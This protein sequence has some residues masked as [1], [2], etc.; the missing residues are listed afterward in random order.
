MAI[1]FLRSIFNLKGSKFVPFLLAFLSVFIVTAFYY[2]Q[3]SFLEAFEA[4]SY[5]LRFKSLRGALQASPEI[6]IIKIDDKSIAELGRFP[7]SRGQ[8]VKLLDQLS[9]AG[10]KAV[11]F[12]IIFSEPEAKAVD[13]AFAVAVKKA[14]NVGLAVAF[15]W[16]KNHQVTKSTHTIPMIAQGAAGVGHI[17]FVPEDDGVNRRN[18]LLV[19]AD[20]VQTPS[21]GLMGAQMAL[22]ER[23]TAGMF[24]IK[25]GD[26]AIPVDADN[27]MWI[28]YMGPPNNYPS[29]S[30]S[31][32]VKGRVNP[33]HL[34]GKVLFVGATAL[35]VYDMRV[36]PFSGNTPGV[37]IHATIADNIIS[38]RFI[39]RTGLESLF[40]IAL[41]LTLGLF[42][43][44]LTKNLGFYAAFPATIV[45]S[46]VYLWFAFWM[47]QQG[48]WV[49]MIYPPLAVIISL[50]IGG[51]FRYLVLE[52][53]ARELR[54]IFSSYHSDK[55]VARLE[56]DPEAA[57]IGGDSKDV[58][59]IFTDIKGFTSFSEKHTPQKVVAR[60]NEYLGA[61]VEVIEEYDGYVDKFIGDGIMAYW[62]APLP[63][64]NHAEL[65]IACVYAMKKRMED[66][67]KKWETEGV[68][69]F[70]IRAGIQSGEVVAGNVGLRGKK[71]EYTVIGDTVNQAARLESSA[72]YYGVDALVGEN[73]YQQT[74]DSFGY[75]ELDKI[76]MVGKQ[77]P[78]TVY[79]LLGMK[80]NPENALS[81]KF[82][83]ALA[84]YRSCNW[85][86]A[87]RSFVAILAE[88]P[89]D[90]PSAI[91]LERCQY[92]KGN[93]VAA[94][95]DGVFN[96]R[97]K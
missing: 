71:M 75:R 16:D 78:V 33:E 73:T 77:V 58:T 3:N 76:R 87:E 61:M 11:L 42:A 41:I 69:P 21:L 70:A 49:S 37:E 28:N 14:G 82:S 65:A 56:E 24:K 72:K 94:G 79:E 17:N 67:C 92:F 52:R 85:E 36:T 60:L 63:Q 5:D 26:K 12:D 97:A 55:L 31:D 53:S 1:P 47:F 38:G 34:K 43:F 6:G 84:V 20:G 18:Q 96:R 22:G 88:F 64:E 8:Y 89:E 93:P 15:D 83:A 54:S 30:F 4:K 13:A 51:S 27:R 39:R 29:F 32:I 23:A 86:E 66:L 19:T 74:K 81:L 57:K 91:Y 40:D 80:T 2:N 7:W 90:R 45:L 95:W 10:A 46:A 50:L 44:Y 48:H 25:I 62:G 35:G 9:A 59:I 68:E